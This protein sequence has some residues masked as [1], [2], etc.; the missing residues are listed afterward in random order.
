MLAWHTFAVKTTENLHSSKFTMHTYECYS[1]IVKVCK[2]G[3][4]D[5]VL[6]VGRRR[7]KQ[8]IIVL[9]TAVAQ[10]GRVK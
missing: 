7:S 3:S 5:H 6:I 9:F 2:G 10:F 8:V 4:P 1:D